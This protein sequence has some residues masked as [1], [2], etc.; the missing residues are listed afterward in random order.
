MVRGSGV[1]VW[2]GDDFTEG[3]QLEGQVQYC[4]ATTQ[5][6]QVKHCWTPMPPEVDSMT[7]TSLIFPYD[8]LS[9]SAGTREQHTEAKSIL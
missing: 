9:E 5:G 4:S 8:R 1:G 3:G 7:W 2:R 6:L